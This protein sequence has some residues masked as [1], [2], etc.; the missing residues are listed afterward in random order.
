MFSFCE[1][2]IW[3][4]C[5]LKIRFATLIL[6]EFYPDVIHV[7]LLIPIPSDAKS[8]R[9]PTE[10]CCY[11][12]S[13][14]TF[15]SWWNLFSRRRTFL[16]FDPQFGKSLWTS[17][18]INGLVCKSFLLYCEEFVWRCYRNMFHKQPSVDICS[19]SRKSCS[20]ILLR[21]RVLLCFSPLLNNSLLE[22]RTV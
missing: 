5:S 19:P 13:L 2:L 7:I 20:K 16:S 4:L 22:S 9:H 1:I 6:T 17:D 15:M 21:F 3:S 18:I 14:N 8:K 10:V 11:T 12:T